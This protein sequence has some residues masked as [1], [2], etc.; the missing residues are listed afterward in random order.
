M[1]VELDAFNLQFIALYAERQRCVKRALAVK[2]NKYAKDRGEFELQYLG[3]MG[4]FALH[5]EYG[6]PLNMDVHIGG[7]NGIDIVING[8]PCHVKTIAFTGPN[9]HYLMDDMSCFTAP[10]GICCQALSPTKV[11]ILGCI[12]RNE[13]AKKSTSR[14]FG[15]GPRL[16]LPVENL[17]PIQVLFDNA[18]PPDSGQ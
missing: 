7:D 11:M 8:W 3:S 2:S 4:E 15:Y 9:P 16:S 13:F 17:K 1:L 10:V 6:S 18:P 14:D 12:H 5:K